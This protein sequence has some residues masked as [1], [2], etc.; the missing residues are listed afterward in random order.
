MIICVNYHYIREDFTKKY[1]SIFGIK[2]VEFKNQLSELSKIGKF[3]SANDLDHN[4]RNNIK[5]KGVKFLVTFDDGLKEQFNTA[6]PILE[7]MGIPAL[8]FINCSTSKYNKVEEVHKIHLIRSIISPQE[9]LY[10]L[11][12]N[13]NISDDQKKISKNKGIKHYKY[14]NP[15]NAQLKYLLN[16]EISESKRIKFINNI[17]NKYF[18][19]FKTNKELYMN[20]DELIKLSKKKMLGSHGFNHIAIGKQSEKIIN[21]EIIDSYNYFKRL[22]GNR[23]IGFSFPYGS[24]ESINGTRKILEKSNHSFALS[25]ERAINKDLSDPFCLARFDNNDMPKGKAFRYKNS[26]DLLKYSCRK[27]KI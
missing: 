18:D 13:V 12:K 1:E 21:H 27:W 4:I 22:T 3:I 9:I 2:P 10:E 17:F 24:Y 5:I 23:P 19:E 26:M 14:D 11:E 7:E 16:F 20:D 6:L 15:N 25:M 8:F